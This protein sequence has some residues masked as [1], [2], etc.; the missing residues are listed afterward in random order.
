MLN[1]LNDSVR[2]QRLQVLQGQWLDISLS[3]LDI[4]DQCVRLHRNDD[5]GTLLT[6]RQV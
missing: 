5:T 6:S 1:M 3:F 4:F 2:Q